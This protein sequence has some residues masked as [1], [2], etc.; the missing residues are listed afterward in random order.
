MGPTLLMRWKGGGVAPSKRKNAGPSG[1]SH[2]EFPRL[3]LRWDSKE[4][5]SETLNMRLTNVNCTHSSVL[6]GN[7]VD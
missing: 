4:R 1:P 2:V 7:T 3:G 6:T 5:N